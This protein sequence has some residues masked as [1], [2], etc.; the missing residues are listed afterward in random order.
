MIDLRFYWSLLMR[1]LPVMLALLIVCSAFGA[2]WAIRAPSTYST[3]AR[4]LVEGAQIADGRD[5]GTSAAETLQV[6]EEQLLTRANMIDVANKLNL[7][8]ADSDL[9][10]DAKTARMLQNTRINRSACGS[11]HADGG[12]LYLDRSAHGRRRGQ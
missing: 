4:L 2:V 12:G 8:G 3:Y 9:D 5:F 11:G 7:F 6:I 1:R 10:V